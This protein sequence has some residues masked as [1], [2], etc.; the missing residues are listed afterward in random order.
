MDLEVFGRPVMD[1]GLLDGMELP[2]G[3]LDI[4]DQGIMQYA[5][6]AFEKVFKLYDMEAE[7]FLDAEG[8][9]FTWKGVSDMQEG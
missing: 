5:H 9:G 2:D 8:G 3:C 1:D 7:E 4:W 6:G